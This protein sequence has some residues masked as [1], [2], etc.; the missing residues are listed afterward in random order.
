MVKSKAVTAGKV[1]VSVL[2][3]LRGLTN[4]FAVAQKCLKVTSTEHDAVVLMNRLVSENKGLERAVR[5]YFSLENL[6]ARVVYDAASKLR[7]DWMA[8]PVTSLAVSGETTPRHSVWDYPIPLLGV[9]IME[10]T[11]EQLLDG[12]K[13]NFTISTTYGNNGKLLQRLAQPLNAK[14][15]VK[16]HWKPEQ[17]AEVIYQFERRPE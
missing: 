14:Q 16:D 8:E 1:Q 17:V 15:R 12:A 13:R 6:T 4:P 2:E 10:A 11:K 5:A 9:S 7:R 3:E